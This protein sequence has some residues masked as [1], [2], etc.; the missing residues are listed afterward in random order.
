M[1]RVADLIGHATMP[2][3]WA[4]GYLQSSRHIDGT[5]ELRDLAT[6]FRDKGLPCDGLIFLSTYGSAKGWNRGVGHLEFEPELFADPAGLIGEF[7][8]QHF[9]VVSHEYPVL[10]AGSPLHA[11]A[12]QN[13]YL[14]DAGYPMLPPG[15]PR[16]T[17]YKEG[18]LYLDFSRADAREWWWRQHRH[19]VDLSL[20]AARRHSS[21]IA[22]T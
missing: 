21:T 15:R 9:H 16:A 8:R 20:R 5:D 2:P 7:R 22:T 13:G 19:L 14:L 17:N 11:E 6:T 3:R 10:H 18:Q 4:L 1:G 12:A